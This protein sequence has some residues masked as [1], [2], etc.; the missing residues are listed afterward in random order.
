[1]HEELRALCARLGKC[2]QISNDHPVTVENIKHTARDPQPARRHAVTHPAD[3]LTAAVLCP[4]FVSVCS[5]AH[6]EWVRASHAA[7][8]TTTTN[9]LSPSSASSQSTRK[10]EHH[11]QSRP[12]SHFDSL[13]K[14][15]LRKASAFSSFVP[16]SSDD[17]AAIL[18]LISGL[19]LNVSFLLGCGVGF[20]ARTRKK[21]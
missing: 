16:R 10:N 15:A 11:F 20:A 1:M 4:C 21:A 8:P 14:P 17:A 18:F 3:A 19:S 13:L 2:K 5:L 7:P 12:C 9:N 6:S